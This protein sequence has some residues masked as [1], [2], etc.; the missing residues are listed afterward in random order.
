MSAVFWDKDRL[1]QRVG[2]N[3]EELG[4]VRHD[5]N[6]NQ[7][8]L[9]LKDT[10]GGSN[11][12]YIRGDSFPSMQDAKQNAAVSTSA[13]LFHYLWLTKPGA[14]PEPPRQKRPGDWGNK[15]LRTAEVVE[16]ITRLAERIWENVAPYLGRLRQRVEG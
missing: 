7:V 10:R 16:K 14:P 2:S 3:R 13:Q 6:S 11:K 1:I 4:Y 12:G 15:S 9:W 8:V 5:E